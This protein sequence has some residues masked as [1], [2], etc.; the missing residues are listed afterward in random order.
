MYEDYKG[1]QL[2]GTVVA[3][4]TCGRFNWEFQLTFPWP[5]SMGFPGGSDGKD[6]ACNVGDP[7]SVPGL[8]SSPGA[9]EWLLTLVF[10]PREFHGQRSLA[11]YSL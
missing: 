6:S 10:L 8:G 7:G 11:G 1:Q 4:L 9:R 2:G 3:K 5:V